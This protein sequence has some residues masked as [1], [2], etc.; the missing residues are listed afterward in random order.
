[1]EIFKNWKEKKQAQKKYFNFEDWNARDIKE[2]FRSMD[3]CDP[4]SPARCK[5]DAY[6][7]RFS[8]TMQEVTEKVFYSTVGSMDVIPTPIGDKYDDFVG[9]LTEWKTRMGI[10]LGISFG[11]THITNKKY[12][13]DKSIKIKEEGK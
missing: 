8:D 4:S 1:M 13:I 2:K 12:F 3:K 7:N 5:W 6:I 9:Y 10:L 11:G